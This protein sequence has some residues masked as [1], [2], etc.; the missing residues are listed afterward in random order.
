MVFAEIKNGR[1]KRARERIR[2]NEGHR[3]RGGQRETGVMWVKG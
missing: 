3:G 2:A 1:E